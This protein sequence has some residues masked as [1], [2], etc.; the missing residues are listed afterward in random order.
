MSVQYNVCILKFEFVFYTCT[1]TYVF[2]W[3]VQKDLSLFATET[4]A[5]IDY[6]KFMYILSFII[7]IMLLNLN[8]STFCSTK[9]Y[10]KSLGVYDLNSAFHIW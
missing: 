1:P 2:Y 4:F 6:S 3:P 10:L 5:Q 8:V 9:K 7:I